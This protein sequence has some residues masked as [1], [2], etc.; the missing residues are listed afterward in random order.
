[1]PKGFYW[2][3][4]NYLKLKDK[5]DWDDKVLLLV[6]IREAILDALDKLKQ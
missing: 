6:V 4:Q 3:N 5:L 2:D 1:M